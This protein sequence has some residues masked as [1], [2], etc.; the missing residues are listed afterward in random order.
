MRV[1]MLGVAQEFQHLPL[2]A[3]LYWK[4]WKRARAMKIHQA[5]ASLI[6]ESNTRMRSALERMGGEVYKT[7][8]NYEYSLERSSVRSEELPIAPRLIP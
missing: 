4:T 6:L 7:Y 2:G 8:R 1:F 5:E 3:P